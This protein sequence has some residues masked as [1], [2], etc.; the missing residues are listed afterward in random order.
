MQSMHNE[1]LEGIRKCRNQAGLFL[2]L[3][4][5]K[6]ITMILAAI[7]K[8]S[9]TLL[10][11]LRY[12]FPHLVISIQRKPYLLCSKEKYFTVS[13]GKAVSLPR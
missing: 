1:A 8:H 9:P 10:C 6:V 5:S 11:S 4:I 12:F 7:G 3:S 13:Q 2:D